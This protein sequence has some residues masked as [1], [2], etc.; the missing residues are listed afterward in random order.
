[1]ARSD[2]ETD[3]TSPAISGPLA[4][5][6]SGVRDIAALVGVFARTL[7]R[8]PWGLARSGS[9]SCLEALRRQGQISDA[10]LFFV[11]S[12]ICAAFAASA[13]V[14][15]KTV[16]GLLARLSTQSLSGYVGSTLIA[17][18]AAYAVATVSGWLLARLVGCT[19]KSARDAA[20]Y[21]AG[22]AG[23]VL[24]IAPI[25]RLTVWVLLWMAAPAEPGLFRVFDWTF[26]IAI[27]LYV[28]ACVLAFARAAW[29][30]DRR[31]AG[32]S[33]RLLPS[34]FVGLLVLLITGGLC[35]AL[36]G[37]VTLLDRYE[38]A[39]AVRAYGSD[40]VNVA[41]LVRCTLA[42]SVQCTFFAQTSTSVLVFPESSIQPISPDMN[43]A[44][45]VVPGVG[46]RLPGQLSRADRTAWAGL[47]PFQGTQLFVVEVNAGDVCELMA[48]AEARGP[49]TNNM[50]F[51]PF[52]W[53]VEA[54]VSHTQPAVLFPDSDEA[55]RLRRSYAPPTGAVT[56]TLYG[57]EQSLDAAQPALGQRCQELRAAARPE[58]K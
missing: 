40:A 55:F 2:T 57:V 28:G 19:A 42:G 53:N 14:E 22:C 32:A 56:F 41:R 52:G 46:R 45:N 15:V 39:L 9:L 37:G 43:W 48:W 8:V 35:T 50:A 25:L 10:T 49:V 7:V 34:A 31:R 33:R 12:A 54:T 6:A 24:A 23:L 17:F 51:G 21:V 26:D 20:L 18:S 16:P 36:L 1:M 58:P 11:L 3:P 44:N 29:L 5:T 13:A 4:T 47:L 30:D 38:R 27:V